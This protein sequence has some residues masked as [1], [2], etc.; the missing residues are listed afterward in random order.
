MGSA[1][2]TIEQRFQA[3]AATC[4]YLEL[5]NRVTDSTLPPV[6]VVDMREELKN[7]NRGIFSRS[8]AESLAETMLTRRA[9]HHLPQPPRNSYLHLL[10]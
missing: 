5:P 1:T 10:P 8:L 7:G 2:P 4:K 6:Q 9:G 3:E